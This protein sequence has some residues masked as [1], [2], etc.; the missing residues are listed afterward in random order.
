MLQ[1]KEPISQEQL[2]CYI[3]EAAKVSD[4]EDGFGVKGCDL[5]K[6]TWWAA[7]A[8][9]SLEEQALNSRLPDYLRTCA[10]EAKKLGA[11]V[12]YEYIFYDT[13]TGEHLERPNMIRLRRLIAERRISGVIFPALDR[14]SREPIHIGIFEFEAQYV[15]IQLHYADAPNGSD[16]MSQMVR[17]NIASA[18]KFVKLA[19]H[20]NAVGGNIG[21][22]VKGLAPAHRAAYG[23]RYRRDAEMASDGRMHVKQAWWEVDELGPDGK[24]VC[25]SPAW[26]VVQIFTW[27]GEEGRTLHWVVKQ[28]NDMGIKTAEGRNWSPG[29]VHKI[30]HRKCYSGN[31]A[32]NVNARVPNPDRPIGDITA[33]VK[34]TLLKPKPQQEWVTFQVPSLVSEDLCEK[35]RENVI[36]RGEGRGKQ[37]KSIQALLRNRLLC[38]RC[39]A[40]MV[41]RRGGHTRRVYYYCSRYFRPWADNPCTYNKFI[42]GTWDDLI[43]GDV[44]TW[45]RNDAWVDQQ[46]ASEQSQDENTTKLIKLQRWNISQAQAKIGKVR[47]GF[48]GGIYTLDEAKR[49]ITDYQNTIVRAEGEIQRLQARMRTPTCG[50]GDIAAMREELKALRD[51]NLDEATFEEKLDIVSK[52]GIKVYPSEDLASMRVCCQLNLDRVQT[53]YRNGKTRSKEIRVNGECESLIG[54]RKV[55]NA[56]LRG[57]IP[58]WHDERCLQ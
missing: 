50:L 58:R 49:R 15:G 13:V 53:E 6:P 48:D 9:Q 32:Y 11:V 26:V 54:C 16:P 56:P 55:Y 34:R 38:P 3:E 28:L 19:N 43:W 47:E 1:T 29:K 25:R 24:L 52:L 42:P 30:V 57:T 39:G 41:V 5:T 12:T 8:R 10:Q 23:Y 4:Y 21:R 37:G 2:D 17:M 14:L 45:L 31:H 18:A 22:V 20:K 44:C 33:E 7:Y 36:K 46:L 35:A 51:K 27:V 40:P